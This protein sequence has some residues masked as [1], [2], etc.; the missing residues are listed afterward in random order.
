MT[1][2]RSLRKRGGGQR[3]S[4]L[5]RLERIKILLAEGKWSPDEKSIFGLPKVKPE[6]LKVLRAMR[7]RSIEEMVEKSS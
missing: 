4:V 5:T 2:H 3:R 6:A 1:M 7:G